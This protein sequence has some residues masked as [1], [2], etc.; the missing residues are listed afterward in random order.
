MANNNATTNLKLTLPVE[1][2]INWAGTINDNFE[3]IDDAVG[4]IENKYTKLVNTNIDNAAIFIDDDVTAVNFY[5][6]TNT[7]QLILGNIG[8]D[9]FSQ[10]G[11]ATL[12]NEY[13]NFAKGRCFY[14]YCGLGDN[15]F[16]KGDINNTPPYNM[17]W[18]N[19][20]IM[21]FDK[22][23]RNGQYQVSFRKMP[24]VL[25]KKYL[26]QS[27]KAICLND[28]W[29][30]SGNF[31]YMLLDGIDGPIG[32]VP[33]YADGNNNYIPTFPNI[34]CNFFYYNPEN[35]SGSPYTEGEPW[36]KVQ[37]DYQI[38]KEP[39]GKITLWV[40]TDDSYSWNGYIWAII[41]YR[42]E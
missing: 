18:A 31:R 7:E 26:N 19:G 13:V 12:S 8:I 29:T 27:T 40:K 1:Q 3:K 4:E 39:K 2:D 10:K 34:E 21:V 15:A 42:N 5:N 33:G 16:Y 24:Q 11:T 35:V 22:E 28:T 9:G 37:L 30:P 32:K 23:Y 20:D 41:N 38:T 6:V 17:D 14:V 36:E 25:G